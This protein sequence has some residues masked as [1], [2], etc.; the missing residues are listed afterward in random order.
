MYH[1]PE[2]TRDAM[3]RG[4]RFRLEFDYYSLGLVLLKIGLWNRITSVRASLGTELKEKILAKWVP[5]LGYCVGIAYQNAV[6]ACLKGEFSGRE[7]ALE[8]KAVLL[9]F[10][11]LMKS[12]EAFYLRQQDVLFVVVVTGVGTDI[13]CSWEFVVA[14]EEVEVDGEVALATGFV[15]VEVELVVPTKILVDVDAG[16]AEV[17]VDG[18]LDE[19]GGGITLKETEAPQ[20]AKDVP[21]GQHPVSVQYWPAGQTLYPQKIARI[22]WIP[23]PQ[24]NT[25]NNKAIEPIVIEAIESEAEVETEGEDGDDWDNIILIPQPQRGSISLNPNRAQRTVM[26]PMDASPRRISSAHPIDVEGNCVMI[27]SPKSLKISEGWK[28]LIAKAVGNHVLFWSCRTRTT[29]QEPHPLS[30][31]PNEPTA[32]KQNL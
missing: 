3:R 27:W 22:Q 17:L 12:L 31:T 26:I 29:L 9:E 8:D 16:M 20:S 1:H 14:T 30:V 7:G 15:A 4:N 5:L 13:V 25:E 23:Q 32:E 18:G 24:V 6:A 2:Y 10:E 11:R 21:S 19:A 28:Y